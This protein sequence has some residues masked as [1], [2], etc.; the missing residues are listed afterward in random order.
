MK[1]YTG[2]WMD[3]KEAL[4]IHLKEDKV[5]LNKI[6]SNIEDKKI[7]GGSRSKVPYGP[8][9]NTSESKHLQRKKHQQKKY[10]D[11]IF[12][13]IKGCNQFF[14]MGPSDTKIHFRTYWSNRFKFDKRLLKVQTVDSI[15]DNQKIEKVKLFFHNIINK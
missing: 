12:E 13:S 3:R 8:M 15:T 1:T 4:I 10:F 7:G 9:D 11:D 2:I 14:I 5:E 6:D